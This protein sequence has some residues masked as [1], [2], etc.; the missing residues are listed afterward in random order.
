MTPSLFTE[1]MVSNDTGLFISYECK[2]YCWLS[3]NIATQVGVSELER[4]NSR[5][6]RESL[7]DI[8]S[9]RYYF[10]FRRM[11]PQFLEK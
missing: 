3:C 11:R 10:I 7:T 9:L 5:I 6:R 4:I 2:E 1:M 8:S